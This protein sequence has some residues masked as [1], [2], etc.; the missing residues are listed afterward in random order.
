MNKKRDKMI[1]LSDEF[2]YFTDSI[3]NEF[4]KLDNV[5][6]EMEPSTW[7]RISRI[8]KRIAYR[9]YKYIRD[10]RTRIKNR[11]FDVVYIDDA[12]AP[13]ADAPDTPPPPVA[14]DTDAAGTPAP[15]PTAAVAGAQTQTAAPDTNAPVTAPPPTTSEA[16][17]TAQTAAPDTNAPAQ[18][19]PPLL[20]SE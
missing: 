11:C 2:Q 1:T 13:P 15:A 14:I 6:E 16:G 5:K 18:A 20:F 10:N 9:G 8:L 3:Y 7:A 4:H 19:G 12:P 17:T